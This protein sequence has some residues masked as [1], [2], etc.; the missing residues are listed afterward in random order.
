M[1]AAILEWIERD[2]RVN[3]IEADTATDNAP[4][5]R[6]LDRLGFEESGPGSEPETLRYQRTTVASR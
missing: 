5:R 3:R 6:L 4:S 2:A 1:M